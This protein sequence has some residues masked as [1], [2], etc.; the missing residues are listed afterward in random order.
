VKIANQI[1]LKWEMLGFV[2][3]PN[4]RGLVIG[5]SNQKWISATN[6]TIAKPG[7]GF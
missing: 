7:S 3:Q 2:A 1:R 6:G 5:S 4:P